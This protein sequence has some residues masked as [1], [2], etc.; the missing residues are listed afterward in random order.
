[1]AIIRSRKLKNGQETYNVMIRK[2]VNG[3]LTNISKTFMV[4]EDA[5]LFI[6]YKERLMTNMDNFEIPL[7][8]RV[9][10]NDLFDL[11]QRESSFGDRSDSDFIVCRERCLRFLKKHNF[12]SELSFEDWKECLHNMSKMEVYKGSKSEKNKR[13][14]S[15]ASLRRIF[16]VVSSVYS[17]AIS[18]GIPVEN[19]PL[20][21]VQTCINNKI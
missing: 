20:K 14:I 16:A 13:I 11:K 4:K 18:K 2:K 19:H 7:E 6:F 10:L 21:V 12:V 15:I 9:T 5:E 3:T 17:H 8:Q 1:M